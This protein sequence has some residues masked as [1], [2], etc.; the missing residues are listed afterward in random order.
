MVLSFTFA[1]GIGAATT[2]LVGQ[3]LGKNRPDLSIMYGKIGLRLAFGVA[4]VLSTICIL[5]R[6]QFPMLFS[7]YQG[8]INAA[9]GLIVLLALI[10]PVQTTQLVMGGSLRGAGD[11]RFVAL[12]MILTVGV[13]RPALGFL[14]T[15][16]LGWGLMGAWV[17][18]IFDQIARLIMLFT[19]FVRGRWI[20]AKL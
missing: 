13:L 5:I 16:P 17:A 8:I 12:T 1:D 7:N 2:S 9:A 3:N 19:R 11:T 20:M 18:I 10:M 4:A 14:F 15:F 6:F